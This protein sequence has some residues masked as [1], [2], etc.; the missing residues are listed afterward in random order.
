MDVSAITTTAL[1]PLSSNELS[2]HV[3]VPD[4]KEVEEFKKMMAASQPVPE[5][6]LVDGIQQQQEM[7]AD[8][9]AKVNSV[10]E[11]DP[12][13]GAKSSSA[14]NLLSTQYALFNLSFTLD[15]T[16][17]VAGQFSQAVNKLTAMQ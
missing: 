8:T 7:Y 6:S 9:I 4:V 16:A 13:N 5:A 14:T 10:A 2:T 3:N 11:T 17:K 12:L 1:Q 15:L